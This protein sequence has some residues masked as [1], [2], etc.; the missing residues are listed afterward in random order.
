MGLALAMPLLAEEAK[1]KKAPKKPGPEKVAHQEVAS[2]ILTPA[3]EQTPAR[4]TR[5]TRT[6]RTIS[7]Q[8]LLSLNKSRSKS[9]PPTALRQAIGLRQILGPARS[10]QPY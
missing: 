5:T 3:P 4:T 9:N 7:N 10:L 8:L 2:Q 6:T 1:D